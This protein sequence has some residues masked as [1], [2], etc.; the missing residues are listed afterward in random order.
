MGD[1]VTTTVPASAGPGA[2]V[3]V[4]PA[5]RGRRPNLTPMLML[6]PSAIVVGVVVVIPI[7]AVFVESF[8]DVNP[9]RHT[10]WVWNGLGNYARIF[11]DPDLGGV[12]VN[13]AVWTI[14]SVILQFVVAFA[15]ALLVRD[16][17]QGKAW[18]W[19]RASYVLPWATPMIVGALAW[20]WL[21]QPQ[22]GLINFVLDSIGLGDWA[23]PWLSD[24]STALYSVLLVNVWRG[25]PFIMVLLL[26]G[27]AAISP[28]IYEAS[29]LD[30]AT[31]WQQT[32][33]ITLPLLR[34]QVLL[35]TLMSLIWTFNNFSLIYV[36]T[37]GGPAG[38]SDILTTYVYKNAFQKFDMGYASALSVVLFVI[39][40]AGSA[41]YVRALDKETFE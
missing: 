34:P 25:F 31:K 29:S 1:P 17:L 16:A 3:Q 2:S 23:Q 6:A 13:T 9:S 32:R 40:A 39:V 8:F 38:T 18:A 35:S 41:L 19:L 21:Y 20:K 12:L 5:R 10:G 11:K 4:R 36:M 15:A 26:A 14:G 28:D 27:M 33:T 30:G 22:Y 37:G 24:P 7:I